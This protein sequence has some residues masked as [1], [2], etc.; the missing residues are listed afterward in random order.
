MLYL[1]RH[2]ETTWNAAGRYQGH[3][4]SPLTPRGRDQAA[5]LGRILSRLHRFSKDPLLAYVSPL[6]RAQESADI[7]GRHVSLNRLDEPRVMEVSMGSWDGMTHYEVSMEYPEALAES[8]RYDWYFRSPDGE[9]LDAFVTR[10]SSW[11][12]DARTPAVVIS[13]GVTGRIIRGL[14]LGLSRSEMLELP[15]PQ[16]GLYALDSGSVRFIAEADV[17]S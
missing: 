13:H 9:S 7:I 3:Q 10:I 15:T 12:K 2:G 6:G 16:D 17:V 11:L 14:Y 1:L 5:S 8:S 4:D